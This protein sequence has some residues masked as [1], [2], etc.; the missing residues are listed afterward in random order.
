MKSIEFGVEWHAQMKRT[1]SSENIAFTL[2]ARTLHIA[3]QQKHKQQQSKITTTTTIDWLDIMLYYCM[4]MQS[5]PQDLTY[6]TEYA[7]YTSCVYNRSIRII[8]IN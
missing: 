5:H 2:H 7:R 8:I 4:Y 6:E 1:R 3:A